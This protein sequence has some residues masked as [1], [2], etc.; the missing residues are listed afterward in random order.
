VTIVVRAA[1]SAADRLAAWRIREC[2]FVREQGIE[3]RIERDGLDDLAWHLVARDDGETVGTARVLGLDEAGGPIPLE[4]ARVAK[5][6]RMAVVAEKRR[7]GIGSRLLEAALAL[8]RRHGI[9][10]VELSA[11][12]YVAPFYE[13]AGFRIEGEGYLE[14]GIPH[15]HMSR[16]LEPDRH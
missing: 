13:R 5:I 15:R 1:R 4:T 6:G 9:E 2:V 12:E 3:E 7:L 10:R 11:Q 8:C 16:L 14:A